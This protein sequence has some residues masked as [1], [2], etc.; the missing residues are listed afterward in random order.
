M[1]ALYTETSI[2]LS[3]PPISCQS[4]QGRVSERMGMA[5]HSV[6]G[7][8][9]AD[10]GYRAREAHGRSSVVVVEGPMINYQYYFV[11]PYYSCGI[12]CPKRY[13]NYQGP[14][15]KSMFREVFCQAWMDHTHRK[16]T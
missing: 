10:L 12:T 7:F 14:Y 16:G 5:Q 8:P 3:S 6:D 2:K 4:Y 11:A 15:L 13:S 1:M 9:R